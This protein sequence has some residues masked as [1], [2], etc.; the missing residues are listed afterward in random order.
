MKLK[1][2]LQNTPAH[3]VMRFMKDAKI[4]NEY[5]AGI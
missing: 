4:V 1:N 5:K 2:W 3:I